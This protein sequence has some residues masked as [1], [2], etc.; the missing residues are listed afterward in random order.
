MKAIKFFKYWLV[1][2]GLS[3]T[4]NRELNNALFEYPCNDEIRQDLESLPIKT[5]RRK[6]NNC[7]NYLN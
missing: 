1:R 6:L 5:L 7:K 3:I 4:T 2:E